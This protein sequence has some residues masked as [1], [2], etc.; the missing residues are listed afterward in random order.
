VTI[1]LP[2]KGSLPADRHA[3]LVAEMKKN[4]PRFVRAQLHRYLE[5]LD[6]HGSLVPRLCDSGAMAWVVFGER[7]D[8]GLTDQEGAGSRS[9]LV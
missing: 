6:R 8:V 4:D 9:A 5:S 3:A 7:D 1:R 2:V